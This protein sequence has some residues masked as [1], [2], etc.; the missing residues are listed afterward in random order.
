MNNFILKNGEKLDL[1]N[2]LKIKFNNICQKLD[3]SAI[4]VSKDDECM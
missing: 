1:Q 2:E 4:K 3:F